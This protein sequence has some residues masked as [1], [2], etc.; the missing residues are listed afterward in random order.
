M[1]KLVGREP[2]RRQLA[3]ALE[4]AAAKAATVVVIEGEPG[5]GKTCLRQDIM[6]RATAQGWITFDCRCAEFDGDRPFVPVVAALVDLCDTLGEDVPT[7]INDALDLVRTAGALTTSSQGDHIARL[8]VDGLQEVSRTRALLVLVDDAHWIDEASARVIWDLVRRRRN[9]ALMTVATF[10]PSTRDGVLAL[11]RALDSH[12]ASNM[13]LSSL[14]RSDALALA[15]EILRGPVTQEAMQLLD[16]AGGNPLFITELLKG[17]SEVE[18]STAPNRQGPIPEALVSLVSR[19]LLGFSEQTRNLLFDAA[20]LGLHIDVRILGSGHGLDVATTLAALAP[21]FEQRVLVNIDGGLGFQHAVVQAIVADSRPDVSRRIRHRELAEQLSHLG[22]SAATIAE[23]H[24]KSA[25]FHDDD[26]HRWMERAAQEVRPLSLEAALSWLERGFACLPN[27]APTI[28]IQMEIAKHLVLL[29]RLAEAEAICDQHRDTTNSS[30]EI[31]RRLTLIAITTM[32]GRTRQD[33]AMQ[34]VDWLIDFYD[35]ADP[36]QVEMLGWKALLLVYRGDLDEAERVAQR[37]L[38]MDVQSDSTVAVVRPH[39]ALG[40]VALLRG[41]LTLALEHTGMATETYD[42]HNNV[43][44]TIMTPHFS[45]S[46]ALL[47]SRPLPEVIAVIEDGYRSCDRAGHALA[48]LH[49]DPIMAISHFAGGDVEVARSLADRVLGRSEDW[50]SGGI[51]L[52]TIT[53]L[54]AYLAL[55]RDDQGAAHRLSTTAFEELLSGGAQAG[56][57]DFAV[58]C[59]AKV[60]EAQGDVAR[61]REMLVGIWELFAKDASLFT[62]APDLVRLTRSEDRTFAVDVTERAESRAVRSGAA[63]DR[64]NALACRGH[65]QADPVFLE[66]AAQAWGELRWTMAATLVR[67]AIVHSYPDRL[68]SNA[69]ADSVRAV[70]G[71]WERMELTQPIRLLRERH[72]QLT[73]SARIIR[74]THGAGSLSQAE[75]AVAR[76][77]AEGLTNKEIAQRLFVSHRTVDSHVSHALAKLGLSS[78]VQLAGVVAKEFA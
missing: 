55:L 27:G 16:D 31:R 48:R 39:E 72:P 56:S 18:H 13:H 59:I 46:M 6:E 36:Q 25:P 10:R 47:S 62:I 33:E 17:L 12:G 42:H 35:P 68:S 29:G 51:T 73:K 64:A 23:Q 1:T 32:A 40:V 30:D 37:G 60:A 4:R 28:D 21:A 15:A 70:H 19:R 20:L 75:Q 9:T 63:L 78:R 43:F 14:N 49:L 57:A 26:A 41:E 45:R 24:W 74:P 76:L 34:H 22:L 3:A 67:D 2:E 38:D 5:I 54:A 11:R 53:G 71:A 7:E 44:T 50:R 65:L 61:A 52:P 58:F 8:I 77:V 69:L 66:Q